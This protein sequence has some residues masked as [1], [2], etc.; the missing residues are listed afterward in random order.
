VTKSRSSA[1][2]CSAIPEARGW[3]P[4][5]CERLLNGMRRK[6]PP[7]GHYFSAR[8]SHIKMSVLRRG[9]S[10]QSNDRVPDRPPFII[11]TRNILT[12]LS[13]LG[14]NTTPATACF[15]VGQHSRHYPK[16]GTPTAAAAVCRS[17]FLI[18]WAVD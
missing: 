7:A 15:C 18:N 4:I 17:V 8:E 5:T 13:E 3:N 1:L 10:N 2:S 16:L 12:A 11:Q 9:N 14:T 6:S